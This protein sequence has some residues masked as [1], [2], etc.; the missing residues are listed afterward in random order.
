V[1]HVSWQTKD[2]VDG[3]YLITL[4]YRNFLLLA[5][6]GKTNQVYAVQ[7]CIGLDDLRVEEIDNGRGMRNLLGPPYW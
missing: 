5:S 4:L 3:E 7:T 6:A 2:G 1:L